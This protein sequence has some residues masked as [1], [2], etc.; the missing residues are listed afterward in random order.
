MHFV[1]L[2]KSTRE[3]SHGQASRDKEVIKKQSMW[4]HTEQTAV[5]TSNEQLA[6]YQLY[7]YSVVYGNNCNVSV[8]LYFVPTV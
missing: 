1:K 8:T 3:K 5:S 2:I 6:C 7:F 4:N